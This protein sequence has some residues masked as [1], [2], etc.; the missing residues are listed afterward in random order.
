[1][2]CFVFPLQFSYL[3]VLVHDCGSPEKPPFLT[4]G[5]IKMGVLDLLAFQPEEAINP[6][7]GPLE[8]KRGKRKVE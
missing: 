8:K 6:Q 5:P 3:D 1:M 7:D 2:V 4:A